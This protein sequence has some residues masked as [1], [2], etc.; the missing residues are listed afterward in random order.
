VLNNNEESDIYVGHCA[1]CCSQVIE[2]AGV[3]E[4]DKFG[5][6]HATTEK[7]QFKLNHTNE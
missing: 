7:C 2:Y 1:D 6:A 5:Y 4:T 3:C